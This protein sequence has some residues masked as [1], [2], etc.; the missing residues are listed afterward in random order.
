[1]LT[2][3]YTPAS[4]RPEIGRRCEKS[5]ERGQIAWGLQPTLLVAGRLLGEVEAEF[6]EKPSFTAVKLG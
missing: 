3:V 2:R 6:A 4:S 5:A 1:M